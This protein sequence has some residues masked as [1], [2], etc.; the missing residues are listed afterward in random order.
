[1][2][3]T[4]HRYKLLNAAALL[5]VLPTVYF[6]SISVLKY[7]FGIDG[8]FDASSPLLEQWGIKES[9]GWNINLLILMGPVVALCIALFQI[10]HIAWEFTK[11]KLHFRV[12]IQ[13]KM[14]PITIVLLSGL[15]LAIL[16]IYLVVENF[17]HFA[18]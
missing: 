5:L 7:S 10:L 17:N 2:E 4:I 11:E 8:P 16:F 3:T 18:E 14:F 12:T 9:F 1:M 15:V 13:K 6:I